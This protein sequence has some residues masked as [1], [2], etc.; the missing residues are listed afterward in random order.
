MKNIFNFGIVTILLASLLFASAGGAGKTL[1]TGLVYNADYSDT[2]DG[3]SVMVNCSNHIKN[4]FSKSNG[5]YSV[6][7]EKSEC[8]FN[9]PLMV[10]A[11]KNGQIGYKSGNIHENAANVNW[12]LGVVNVT[13]V[14]EFG[15]VVGVLTLL[16]A[17]GMFFVIRKD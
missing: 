1:I 14:P 3:A 9:D 6:T 15:V 12:D 4:V 8:G 7:Y 13:I 5:K 11:E 17:V 10:R 2:I 16:S